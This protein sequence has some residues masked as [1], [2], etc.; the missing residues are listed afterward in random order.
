LGKL[1]F[2]VLQQGAAEIVEVDEGNIARAVRMLFEL[3]NLKAEPTG[4]LSLAAVL[5][6]PGRFAG[7]RVACIVSGGNVDSA[8]YAQLLLQH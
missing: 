6:A 1:N 4:A 2:A 5:Q 7:K 3:A 8:L